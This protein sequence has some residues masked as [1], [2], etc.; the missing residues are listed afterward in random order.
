MNLHVVIFSSWTGVLIKKNWSVIFLCIH[1]I[2][3]SMANKKRSVYSYKRYWYHISST[4]N[5]NTHRL[6]PWGEHRGFNRSGNEPSGKRI[7]VAPTIEQC[8]T[9]IPYSLSYKH[10][11]YRTLS[12]V[13]AKRPKDIFDSN[14]TNEGWIESPT[15][16]LKIGVIDFDTVARGLDIDEV[17]PEK[18]T[19][20]E[21]K[22][23]RKLLNWWK[24]A[25]IKRF[26]K[27]C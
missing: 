4:L 26:I 5:R 12:R 15:T 27:K 17:M 20:G 23:S 8:I 1:E 16:F 11:I 7:C 22:E 6:I 3:L 18:A 14:V 13:K 9:A 19:E 2:I 10:T 21:V 24:A 25:K